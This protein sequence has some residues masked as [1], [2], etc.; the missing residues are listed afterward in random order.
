M[1]STIHDPYDPCDPCDPYDP[2]DPYDPLTAAS[3][4][5]AE[6]LF[7]TTFR[8][9]S[10][11]WMLGMSVICFRLQFIHAIHTIHRLQRHFRRRKAC[12]GQLSGPSVTVGMLG[13]SVI[14]FRLQFI[15][16]FV[17]G[18]KEVIFAKTAQAYFLCAQDVKLYSCLH[19]QSTE[20]TFAQV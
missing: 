1:R 3:F 5:K 16:Q 13:M 7:R 4:P 17:R 18:Q 14:C 2:Y 9:I 6:G 10:H 8:T 11:S 12:S 20:S 15:L 19:H